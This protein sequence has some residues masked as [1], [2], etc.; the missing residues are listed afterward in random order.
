MRVR[1][2]TAGG[3]LLLARA[4]RDSGVR[5]GSVSTMAR[6]RVGGRSSADGQKLG[7]VRTFVGLEKEDEEA[8]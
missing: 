1:V 4:S 2:L 5:D 6:I 3:E 7:T 8:L